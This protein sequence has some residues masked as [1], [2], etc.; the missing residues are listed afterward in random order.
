[1]ISIVQIAVVSACIWCVGRF[2]LLAAGKV[3][4]AGFLAVGVGAVAVFLISAGLRAVGFYNFW[5]VAGILG[6][7]TLAGLIQRSFRAA[8]ARG[9]RSWQTAAYLLSIAAL[10]IIFRPSTYFGLG[11]SAVYLAQGFDLFSTKDPT[12][13]PYFGELYA[14]PF[15]YVTHVLGT[16]F[17][18]LSWGNHE[19]YYKFGMYF[20]SVVLAPLGPLAVLLFARR[21]L[22]TWHAFIIAA[23]FVY[24]AERWRIISVRGESLGW[25]VGFGFLLALA[26]WIERERD[27]RES[28]FLIV[29]AALLFGGVAL[30]HGVVAMVVSFLGAGL[31]VGHLSRAMLKRLPLAALIATSTLLLAAVVY[32]AG[33][34]KGFAPSVDLGPIAAAPDSA[35]RIQA[36]LFGEQLH[37]NAILPTGPFAPRLDVAEVLLT[38][39]PASVFTTLPYLP[40]ETFPESA[41]GA[42][43]QLGIVCRL[44]FPLGFAASALLMLYRRNNPL[45]PMYC[46]LASLYIGVVLFGLY[47]NDVSVARYPLAAIRR[48]FS[49]SGFAYWGC[50]GLALASILPPSRSVNSG[51]ARLGSVLFVVTAIL[52]AAWTVS[53]NPSLEGMLQQSAGVESD[54]GELY[55]AMRYIEGRTRS[56]DWVYSNVISDNQFWYL[57]NGRLSLSEGSAMYQVHGLQERAAKRLA[58]FRTFARTADM[59]L[60]KSHPV[61][62]IML[63][64]P[65]RCESPSC[66]LYGYS[67]MP[68]SLSAFRQG[69][70]DVEFENRK[71]LIVKPR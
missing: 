9:L 57:S 47:L 14:M 44:L 8:I 3:Q 25:I 61:A 70:Y 35:L 29:V 66:R 60:I 18:L 42:V 41:I 12:V 37:A 36:E 53:P 38:F 50:V 5:T 48:A 28:L 52:W 46:A 67:V 34:L 26:Q 49:Y 1:M 7:A 43:H 55:D 24:V 21:T 69:A 22:P 33:F 62:L 11:Q 68:A 65:E 59:S 30:V 63:Y 4:N 51:I 54:A 16:T 19:H 31:V 39:P 23:L 2:A 10:L 13:W 64:K 15:T 40:M 17:A 20:I 58:D 32:W 27:D 71:F 56:G 6:L 45:V